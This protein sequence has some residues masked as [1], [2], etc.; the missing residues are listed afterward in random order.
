M[1]KLK[2]LSGTEVIKVLSVFGFLVVRQ[3]GSHVKLARTSGGAREILTVP[4]HKE[5]DIG[6]L[7]AIFRQASRFISPNDLSQYFYT[8]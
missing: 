1:P 5:L 6:T 2:V 4:M 3:K 7:R 8:E